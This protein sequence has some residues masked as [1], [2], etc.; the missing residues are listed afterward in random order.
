MIGGLLIQKMNNIKNNRK[1]WHRVCLEFPDGTPFRNCCD[2]ESI[3]FPWMDDHTFAYVPFGK[4][5]VVIISEIKSD[6]FVVHWA[7]KNCPIAIVDKIKNL[8]ANDDAGFDDDS[9]DDGDFNEVF[10]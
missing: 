5:R 3:K 4:S 10:D 2:F 1:V 6:G 7:V 9:D 8:L